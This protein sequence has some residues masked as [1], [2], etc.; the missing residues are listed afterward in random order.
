MLVPPVETARLALDRPE[1][2]DAGELFEIGSDPRV[3]GHFPSG[4]HTDIA[5]TKALIARWQRSWDEARLG[6]WVIRLRDS[7]RVIGYGGCTLLD[8]GVWNL[9]YRLAADEHGHGYA[10]E[11]AREA[12]DRATR[13]HPDAPVVASLLEHNRAS[14]RVASKLGFALVYRGPDAGNP[15]AAAIRLVYA[16]RALREDELRVVLH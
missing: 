8:G 14:A 1:P 10:T 6:P 3:W 2:D 15:D 9:G 5:Q 16:N 7:S 12:V 13:M 4:R 11:V